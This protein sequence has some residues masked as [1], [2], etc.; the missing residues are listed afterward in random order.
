MEKGYYVDPDADGWKPPWKAERDR[1]QDELRKE[2]EVP[3]DDLDFAGDKRGFKSTNAD[4]HPSHML[5]NDSAGTMAN[6]RQYK[7]G[8]ARRKAFL[9][10]CADGATIPQALKQTGT[11][12]GTYDAW[13][14]RWPLWALQLDQV[15]G[16]IN[17]KSSLVRHVDFVDFRKRYFGYETYLHQ[18]AIIKAIENTPP[19]GITMVLVPPE[20]GKTSVIEDWICYKIACNPNVRI[21]IVSEGQQHARKIM[22]RV[23]ARMMSASAYV[24]DFGP[25]YFPDMAKSGK[26][27]SADMMTVAL[28]THDERDYTIVA[29]GW[30]SAV[31]GSRWD[32]L[33]V[34]DIMSMKNLGQ[35]K[36][37]V[38]TFRQDFLTRPG[39]K[40]RTVITGTRVAVGDFYDVMKREENP[41][42]GEK[43]VTEVVEL[44]ALDVMTGESLCPEMWPVEALIRKR[45]IVGEEVWW[46]NYQQQP[47]ANVLA[48]FRPTDIE[49]AL[50]EYLDSGVPLP[51]GIQILSLDP[52]LGGG[53]VLTCLS[54]NATRIRIV[55]QVEDRNLARTEQIIA[56]ITDFVERYHPNTLVI[57]ANAFQRGLGNDDR[58]L[59]LAA[60]FGFRVLPH[61]TG[62]GGF[63]KQDEI[64]GI[65][66][67]ATTFRKQVFEVPFSAQARP[68]IEPLLGQLYDWQPNIPTRNLVQDRVMSLWFGWLAAMAERKILGLVSDDW[69]RKGLPYKPM[70]VLTKGGY[71]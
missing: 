29:C 40:G 3:C 20:H 58:I 12:K 57:E 38:D 42:T 54:Y 67:M 16:V 62:S 23:K 55:D 6:S 34:D 50:N 68:T 48:T 13:R 28:A 14:A 60:E 63:R 35:V 32:Y 51:G 19:Q 26:P 33:L 70:K 27:W 8:V 11:R 21:G 22:R 64:M 45:T 56:R 47:R 9:E 36:D 52:A 30:R 18:L 61:L 31:A 4:V 69:N 46:R 15:R 71:R 39:T 43:V 7:E 2:L 17:V 25:F 1:R 24:S 49:P 10:A 37:V 59:A 44:P 66:R 65:A 41:I 53:N 5:S